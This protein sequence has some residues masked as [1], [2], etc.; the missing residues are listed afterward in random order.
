MGSVIAQHD[1]SVI[2]RP[3]VRPDFADI[4]LGQ[5]DSPLIAAISLA[6][7][8]CIGAAQID[9]QRVD[10]LQNKM[11]LAHAN[12]PQSASA[13][14]ARSSVRRG[15]IARVSVLKIVMPAPAF[16]AVS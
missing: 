14:S 1:Y 10:I 8:L 5:L 6:T 16:K 7:K 3:D 9:E 11:D 4:L 12:L 15:F 13:G 2:R